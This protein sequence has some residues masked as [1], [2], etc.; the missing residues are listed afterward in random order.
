MSDPTHPNFRV[1]K[2]QKNIAKRLRTILFST[3]QKA[4][5]AIM[6]EVAHGRAGDSQEVIASA[7]EKHLDLPKGSAIPSDSE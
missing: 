5:D 4:F 6:N 2:G 1:G 7:I 3:T